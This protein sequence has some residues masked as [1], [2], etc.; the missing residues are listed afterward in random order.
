MCGRRFMGL[1]FNFKYYLCPKNAIFFSNGKLAE[2]VLIF[3]AWWRL[4]TPSLLSLI[5][6]NTHNIHACMHGAMNNK[7]AKAFGAAKASSFMS[8]KAKEYR[9]V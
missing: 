7:P 2:L 5:L 8:A 1:D 9:S 4:F 3:T 6:L